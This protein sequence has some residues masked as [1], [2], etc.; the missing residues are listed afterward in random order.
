M[1]AADEVC[2]LAYDGN[3]PQFKLKVDNDPSLASAVD[4]VSGFNSGRNS[5]RG[6]V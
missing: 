4:S 3:F 1:S 5:L 2:K 6:F